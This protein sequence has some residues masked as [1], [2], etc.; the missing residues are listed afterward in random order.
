MIQKRISVRRVAW[1]VYVITMIGGLLMLASLAGCAGNEA[2]DAYAREH[3]IYGQRV[4]NTL[5][6][7]AEGTEI[8]T[9]GCPIGENL[10]NKGNIQNEE[11]RS[12]EEEAL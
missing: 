7:D 4:C 2:V 9:R 6:A 11:M 5:I 3:N 12:K 8:L 10:D 1:T